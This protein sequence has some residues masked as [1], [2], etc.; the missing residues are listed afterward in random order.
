MA[1]GHALSCRGCLGIR[2]NRYEFETEQLVIIQV[3]RIPVQEIP[4]ETI[5]IDNN[6]G[7][8]R[9]SGRGNGPERP[10]ENSMNR[11]H[12]R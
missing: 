9:G 11:G 10:P 2:A 12:G 4:I 1:N 3:S 7:N 5:Y 8:G 6:R